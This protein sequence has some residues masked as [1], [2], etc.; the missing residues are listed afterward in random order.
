[1]SSS[2]EIEARLHEVK[3]KRGYLLP[4]HGLLAITSPRMLDA[5]DHAYTELALA[6]RVLSAHD[7][8]FVWLAI[9]IATDEALA[10]HHIGKFRAAGGTLAEL[11]AVLRLAAWAMGGRAYG[12][13]GAHWL[14]HLPGL[15]LDAAYARA[16]PDAGRLAIMAAA[17]VHAC[18]ADW[19]QFARAVVL[20]YAHGVPEPELAEAVS[21]VMFP[22]SVPRFVE[23]ARVWLELIREGRVTPGPAFAAWAALPGQG[24][25]DEAEGATPPAS[26]QHTSPRS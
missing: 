9:L 13:V 19:P 14:V 5:Y 15:D 26:A 3:A 18:L 12:F 23:A 22:G 16:M 6:P 21:L 7:R 10:T 2:D 1:M 8:E 17:A 24:G 25:W 4:H 20:A 11:E